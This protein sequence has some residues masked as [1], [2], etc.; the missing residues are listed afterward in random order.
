MNIGVKPHASQTWT[1]A[2]RLS[3]VLGCSLLLL[4]LWAR[5]TR[6]HKAPLPPDTFAGPCS[7]W[8]PVNDGAFGMGT[9]CDDDYSSEEGF[10]VVVF[11]DQLYVGMEADNDYGARL[12]RT[13]AG[14]RVPTGQADW[15]EVI[16]DAYG[17]PFGNPNKEQNDHIDSLAVF[18]SV[19]YAST[20]NRGTTKHGTLIYSST[21]GAPGS[22]TPVISAGFGDVNNVNFKDMRVFQDWLCGGTQN[23]QTGAQVWCTQDGAQ[24]EQKNVSGFG[25]VS[26]TLIAS[27]GVF[28]DAFGN[29]AFYVGVA[30]KVI[31]GSVWRTDDLAT[32]TQVFT[33]TE[34]P[35]VE[36]A[37]PFDGYLY[38]AE[39]AYDGRYG[40]G[41]LRLYRSPIGDP[42]SWEEVG[43]AVGADPY[44][45]RTIVDGATVYNGALYLATMNT[46]TG[47]EVWRT[48][49]GVT[50]AQ[51]NTGGFG[52]TT[53]F[54]AQLIPY[55]GYLYAWTSDYVTGQRVYRTCCGSCYTVYLPVLLSNH[56]A[57]QRVY[58]TGRTRGLG[59]NELSIKR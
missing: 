52:Y 15:E 42:G 30:S 46:V 41:P 20:A 55:R 36:I 47:A 32:W 21:T 40:G 11:N 7:A 33:S 29:A 50:W 38:I 19:L 13:K 34:H 31:S 8:T 37:A 24:W 44:N 54:A 10:E 18:Q 48:T 14:V 6:A 45:T 23:A 43:H 17:N 26:N 58:R 35:R 53:T 49:D 57:G 1:S 3:F 56:T 59:D 12:W 51:V 28:S 22:W 27:T 2:M 25:L 9:G 4:S 5:A 39:G 16:A